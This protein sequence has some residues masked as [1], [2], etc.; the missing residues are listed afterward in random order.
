MAKQQS[1]PQKAIKNVIIIIK[2]H[3]MECWGSLTEVC[4]IHGFNYN[5]L[6]KR[7]F[8]FEH[9]GWIINKVPFRERSNVIKV[10][11]GA[12]KSGSLTNNQ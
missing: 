8:P 2:Q 3:H 9:N 5:T 12:G 7:K 1:E 10:L 11:K 6:K 4:R